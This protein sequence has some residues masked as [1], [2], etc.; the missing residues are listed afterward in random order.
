M[1]TTTELHESMYG[2]ALQ[3]YTVHILTSHYDLQKVFRIKQ[4]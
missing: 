4:I 3:N 1:T 2:V